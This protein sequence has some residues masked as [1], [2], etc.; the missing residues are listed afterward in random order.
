MYSNLLKVLNRGADQ[1]L[2]QPIYHTKHLHIAKLR[3]KTHRLVV[4]V[5]IVKCA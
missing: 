4:K 2:N 1:R 5:Q 3:Y